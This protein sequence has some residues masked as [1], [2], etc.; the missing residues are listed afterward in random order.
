MVGG[1]GG[2]GKNSKKAGVK[3]SLK[4]KMPHYSTYTGKP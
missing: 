3:I 4:P 1:R 2:G